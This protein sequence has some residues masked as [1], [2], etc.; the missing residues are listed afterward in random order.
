MIKE[1]I[2]SVSL[3]VGCFSHGQGWL[4]SGSRSMS[5]G[6]ASVA[7]NDAWSFFNN[8]G[9]LGELE[10]FQ[11]GLSYEN[12]FLL[13]ELQT[14][15][16]VVAVPL[17]T[18]VIS[19]GGHMYGYDQF[20]SYKGG[21]GYSM[22]LGENLFAGVQ[23]NY[24][25]IR[26]NE[27]YGSTGK[28]TAE[29]GLNFHI[30]TKWKVGVSVFNLGRQKL[31]AYAD[32]RFSTIMR[33]GTSYAFSDKFLLAAEIEKDLEHKPRM[34]VGM[35]YQLVNNFFWRMGFATARPE[36]SFGFSYHFKQL[37]LDLGSSYDQILGWSPNFS[38]TYV[39]NKD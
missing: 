20:R 8:P 37:Y 35:D 16:A 13:K 4:P 9:A 28:L 24:Q 39:L 12:R 11:A 14:Q 23:L 30:N 21:L 34:K 19:L 29:A 7:L 38:L 18:G 33:L 2:L 25:G 10:E 27:N 15:A 26:L 5:M 1:I 32:D 22:A 3:L 6:N 31:A 17:K 36:F